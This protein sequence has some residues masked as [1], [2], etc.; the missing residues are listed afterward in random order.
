M[1]EKADQGMW[2]REI[3]NSPLLRSSLVSASMQLSELLTSRSARLT[4]SFLPHQHYNTRTVTNFNLEHRSATKATLLA[5]TARRA[6]VSV[7]ATIQSSNH[8]L[9][10]RRS[11]QLQTHPPIR[12]QTNHTLLLHKAT[13][14]CHKTSHIVSRLA[15]IRLALL[16]ANLTTVLQ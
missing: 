11:N 15:L 1:Q 3:E 7:L 6:S 14:L 12:L 9:L 10:R 13:Y 4:S 5:A 2:F 16:L 8:S